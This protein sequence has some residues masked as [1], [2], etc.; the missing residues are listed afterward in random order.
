MQA[1]LNFE[2]TVIAF[3]HHSEILYKS[4]IATL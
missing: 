1:F 3:H 4:V 2:T